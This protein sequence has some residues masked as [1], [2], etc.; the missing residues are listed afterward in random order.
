[1]DFGWCC[2][3][4]HF[5]YFVLCTFTIRPDFSDSIFSFTNVSIIACVVLVLL[6]ITYTNYI[7]INNLSF[8]MHIFFLR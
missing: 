2:L 7:L 3:L 8:L 5:R 4:V 6:Y 1:M